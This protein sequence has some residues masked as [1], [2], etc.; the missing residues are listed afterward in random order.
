MKQGRQKARVA[1]GKNTFVTDKQ[2]KTEVLKMRVRECK[3]R[4]KE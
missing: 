3:E 4:K 2:T 1:G